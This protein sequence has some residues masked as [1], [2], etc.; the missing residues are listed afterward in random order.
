[1]RSWLT[2]ARAGGQLIAGAMTIA[3]RFA[4]LDEAG[5]FAAV[6]RWSQ[7]VLQ[8]VSLRLRVFGTPPTAGTGT[9]LVANHVSWADVP[10]IHSV[11][12]A[13][14]VSKSEVRAWPLIGWMAA[15]AGT[16]F[17]DRDRKIAA[18]AM[19]D[20][21][22]AFLAQ[23]KMVALFPEGTTSAGDR[24]LPFYPSLFEPAVQSG[25][26]VQ[27]LAIRYCDAAGNPTDA[28]AFVGEMT[29]RES[30]RRLA[31][32]GGAM[33]ELHFLPR[34]SAQGA[35]RRELAFATHQAIRQRLFGTAP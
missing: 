17:L 18:R 3:S 35:H 26:L 29:L 21:I 22:A 23:G 11:V 28:A 13:H 4:R 31:A 15:Q 1:M 2:F 33:V 8:S 9:L 16:L 6:A 12:P 32:A 27:P 19:N 10:A 30:L 24:V 14:F 7:R 20:T 5:R 25:A 34:R